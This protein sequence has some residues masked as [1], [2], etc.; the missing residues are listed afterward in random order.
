MFHTPRRVNWLWL[1][2]NVSIKTL[3]LIVHSCV[4][5]PQKRKKLHCYTCSCIL[6]TYP[7]SAEK[8]STLVMKHSKHGRSELVFLKQPPFECLCV[9]LSAAGTNIS[10]LRTVFFQDKRVIMTMKQLLIR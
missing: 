9:D 7:D 6:V 5:M 1:G 2:D 4:P 10:S 8:I 3:F